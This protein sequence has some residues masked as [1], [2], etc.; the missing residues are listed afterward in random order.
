MKQIIEIIKL[1]WPEY[2]I[3]IIVITVGILGAFGLNNWNENR[4][5]DK[6][7][8]DYIESLVLD[9]AKDTLQIAVYIKKN[10]IRLDSTAIALQVIYSNPSTDSL[11]KLARFDM[12]TLYST[13]TIF[14]N[15]TFNSL[16]AT[17][18]INLFDKKTIRALIEL[19]R[20]HKLH[21][22][23]TASNESLY[24]ASMDSYS[25]DFGGGSYTGR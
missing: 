20:N 4:K 3:E 2:F 19:D 22:E 21:S 5:T 17:G 6:L 10:E 24:H 25:L 9:L 8:T 23:I 16:I 11:V 15:S 7:K 14:N 18:D 13:N 1:K 12:S